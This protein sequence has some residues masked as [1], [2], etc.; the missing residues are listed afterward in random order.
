M[1]DIEILIKFKQAEQAKIVVDVETGHCDFSG[2]C[3]TCPA[4]AA[5]DHLAQICD[6][7]VDWP[8][9]YMKFRERLTKH[10]TSTRLST[11][12]RHYPEYFL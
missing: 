3:T 4:A 2:D 1:T 6:S 10:N 7:S 12:Q 5:C 8:T 9:E 11:L